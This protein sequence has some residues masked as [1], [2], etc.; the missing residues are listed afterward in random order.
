MKK[1]KEKE[2]STLVRI[3]SRIRSDQHKFAKDEATRRKVKEGII[4]RELFDLGIKN[5]IK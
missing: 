5:Y 2:V 1:I 3:N 4:H